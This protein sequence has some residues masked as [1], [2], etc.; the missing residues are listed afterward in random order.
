MTLDGAQPES[1]GFDAGLLNYFLSFQGQID[2]CSL[3]E[4]SPLTIVV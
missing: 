4:S 3:T 2:M 1:E